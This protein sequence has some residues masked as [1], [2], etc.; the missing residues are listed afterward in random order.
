MIIWHGE[1]E[2]LEVHCVARVIAE[3][4]EHAASG[5][6]R[7]SWG[8]V[9]IGGVLFGKN[10]SGTVCICAIRPAEC[11][12]HYGPAFDLSEKDCDA[13]EL[14]LSA[15]SA[16]EELAGLTPVGWYQSSSR[17]D[18]GLSD[19]ARA[20]FHRFFPGPGQLAMVVRRSKRD[21]MSVGIFVRDLNGGVELHS[22]E[23]EITSDILRRLEP[24][25]A[26]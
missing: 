10:E 2:V 12:H 17:R 23:Q 16:D 22:P 11:E 19:H 25:Q 5:Y 6:R 26:V 18:L 14:L 9:E 15:A 8:G 4:A 1:G 20:F 21:P 13:F 7:Y 24:P 3:I